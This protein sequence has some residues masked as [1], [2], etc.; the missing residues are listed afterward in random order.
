M[1]ILVVNAGSS[2]LKYQLF[3]MSTGEVLAKGIC[4]KIGIADGSGSITLKRPGKDKYEKETP[5]PDHNAALKLVLEILTDAELGVISDISEIGAVGHR[6]AH[7]GKLKESHILDDEILAYIESIVPINPLHG[8]PALKGVEA[9]KKLMPSVPQV[10]VF[11]SSFY[12]NMPEESYVY[13]IPYE[14]T[15]KY[16]IRRYGFHGTS[17][18]YVSQEAAKIVGKPLEEL[19]MITCHIGS[20]SSITAI[21]NGV[22]IDTS[23]GF[24]PQGGLPMGTRCG[25]ID[26]AIVTFMIKQGYTA[27]EVD[28]ALNKKSGLI[29]VS[30]VSSDARDIWDAVDKGNHRAQL[31]MDLLAHYA[32]QLIGSYVAEMNGLDVLVLTAGMGENDDRIREAI[33]TNMEYLGIQIDTTVNANAGRGVFIDLTA[34]GSKV[35]VYVIPTDEELMIAKDTLALAEAQA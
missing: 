30:G 23:M 27:D 32:K 26:P 35:K 15:E 33:C 7:G 34:E 11:D 2:S 14:W 29:G 12:G 21:K 9:C 19:K 10:G 22:A 16:S 4:E 13:A 5:L 18:R 3:D 28:N 25:P 8:P 1:K 17:H 24:T 20:G 6:F 31:S